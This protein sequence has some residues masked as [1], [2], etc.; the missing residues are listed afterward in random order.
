MADNKEKKHFLGINWIVRAQNPVWWSKIALSVLGIPVASAGL[1]FNQITDWGTFFNVLGEAYANPFIVLMIIISLFN[2]I[3]ENTSKGFGD[4]SATKKILKPYTDKDPNNVFGL[5]QTVNE[6]KQDNKQDEVKEDEEEMEDN[7]VVD[8]IDGKEI[9]DGDIQDELE[10]QEGT[11]EETFGN[12]DNLIFGD[13]AEPQEVG[14]DSDE[15]LEQSKVD[16]EIK[17]EDIK[18]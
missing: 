7:E 1:E 6:H 18:G 14:N 3:T 11:A 13:K 15:E 9:S 2:S 16:A 10:Q 4:L 8:G 5:I 12:I 17:G